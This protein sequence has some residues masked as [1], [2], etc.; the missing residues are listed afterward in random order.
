MRRTLACLAAALCLAAAPLARAAD[1]T[2]EALA[3][4]YY[5]AGVQAYSAG[6]FAVA[7]EA[8]SE[9]YKLAKKPTL[10]FSLA[11]AERREYTVSRDP[12]TLRSA[13]AHF[14]QY[15]EEVKEGG[16]RADAVEALG[17]LEA[18]TARIE[19]GSDAAA[20]G[21]AGATSRILITTEAAGA[22]IWIDEV[23]Y[24]ESP[25]VEQLRAGKHVIRVTAPDHLEEVREVVTVDGAILPLAITLREKPSFLV[26]QAP[27]GATVTLD[28]RA[29]GVAPL[30]RDVEVS[31]GVHAVAVTMAGRVP[32]YGRISAVPGQS[33]PVRVSLSLTPQRIA[34][35]GFLGGG[36]ASVLA[37]VG[38]AI[39]ALDAENTAQGVLSTTVMSNIGQS[40]LDRYNDALSRRDDLTKA[41][42]GFFAVG[43]ALGV[44]GAG[45]YLFD[46]REATAPAD[47][48]AKRA[49]LS[50]SVSP[51]GAGV[52]LTGSF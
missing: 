45:L 26:V 27:V 40:D 50:F 1:P 18:V 44:A 12:K 38:L 47:P 42:L 13:V 14:R 46:N 2:P 43:A 7:V 5:D 30:E 48:T 17:D 39:A 29:V 34:S 15:L 37:G 10:L 31:A 36:A 11:Q 49:S 20:S 19:S 8:F 21:K 28:G 51:S 9:A 52:G 25:V 23:E 33:V 6:R 3:K 4:T 22:I 16:R 35:L 32:H 41:S 24:K